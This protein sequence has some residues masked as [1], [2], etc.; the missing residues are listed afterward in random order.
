[1][2]SLLYTDPRGKDECN[3]LVE[4]LG[5]NTLNKITGLNPDAMYTISKLIWIKKHKPEVYEKC[6]SI[7]LFQ[8]YI[9]FMLSGVRQI[10]Y[11]LATRTMAFSYNFV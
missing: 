8:D 1:M 2:D 3:N 11:S 6:K 7:C 5:K 10:D 9:V 4:Y